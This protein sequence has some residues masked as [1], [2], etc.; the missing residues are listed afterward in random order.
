MTVTTRNLF[1]QIDLAE[2]A[3]AAPARLA[4]PAR[5][6]EQ[7]RQIVEIAA[8]R[9]GATVRASDLGFSV[10]LGNSRVDVTERGE[11]LAPCY[12]LDPR[13]VVAAL[14]SARDEIRAARLAPV[15]VIGPAEP[16]AVL[17]DLADF[18]A[19]F[20]AP[21]VVVSESEEGRRDAALAAV[22]LPTLAAHTP[23]GTWRVRWVDGGA[24]V[25][26]DSGA[27]TIGSFRVMETGPRTWA[28]D[29]GY[30]YMGQG[31]IQHQGQTLGRTVHDALVPAVEALEAAL[32]ASQ[33]AA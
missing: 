8:Q 4:R 6:R 11:V 28:V 16:D 18:D 5:T 27:V 15:P 22:L 26:M 31:S 24:R 19:I 10:Q 7:V 33:E 14:E 23:E 21:R 12:T 2:S 32:S 9:I 17:F 13:E 30:R 1:A 29:V 20:A 3:P 25:Y